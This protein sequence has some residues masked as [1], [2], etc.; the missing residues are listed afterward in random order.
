MKRTIQFCGAART[1]TG[2]RHLLTVN[3]KRILVDCGL[4]QGPKELEERNW[5]PFPI[6]PHEID[7][8]ILTH[9]HMDH[10]GY[11]PRLVSHGFHGPIFSTP[12]TLQLAR[13][14]LPDSGRIQEEDARY[15]NKKRHPQPPAEPLYTEG[16]AY[17]CMKRFVTVQYGLHVQVPGPM[18]LR[19]MPAGHILGSAFAE[20]R[21]DDGKVLLM[22]GDLGRYE[23]PILQDPTP[24][25]EAEWLVIE[26][27]Y[28][29]RLH[30]PEDTKIEMERLVKSA[31][32]SS[33]CLL[34][35]SFA[36]GRTQELLYYLCQLQQENRIPRIPIFVDSPMATATTLLYA[37]N[38]QDHDEETKEFFEAGI[39]PLNPDH[40]EFVRDSNAS[41]ALNAQTGPMMIIAGSGMCNGGRIVHH[42]KHRLS[43]PST[44]VMFTGY[45]AMG[46][47]GRRILDG[48]PTIRLHGEE[49]EVR[50]RIERLDALSAH[51]D[52]NEMLR[53]LE[54]IRS[55]PRTTFIVHGEPGAQEA[56]AEHVHAKFG[57]NTYIPEH[58]ETVE[59]S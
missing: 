36:I 6:P 26:S 43:N 22:S 56:M 2:S 13:V 55:S 33:G 31:V 18:E 24:M 49:I 58:L 35:P 38:R 50:A 11:L 48:E 44:I 4:F 19:F 21:F 46:T 37:Q 52:Y 53:W 41:K 45:Q 16:E 7:A 32:D 34:V 27:T 40:L 9:A 29:D 51:A 1:V 57:W 14:S 54:G 17:A 47:T 28:G 8:V 25:P 23:R 3:N 59:L 5:E 39:N 15:E 10:I 42:L 12:G 30:S 20:L